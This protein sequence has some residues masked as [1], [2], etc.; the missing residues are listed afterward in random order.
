MKLLLINPIDRSACSFSNHFPPLGFG[1]LAALT[2]PDIQIEFID[3]NFEE[4]RPRK[5]DLVAISSMTIQANRTYEICRYYKSKGI[6]TIVGGIHVSMLPEEAL[7]YASSVIV[8]EAESLWPQAIQDFLD[9]QL[10]R[11]YKSSTFPSLGNLVT[12]RRDIFNKRYIYDTIQTSRGCPFTCDFCSVQVFNG[13]KYRLRPIEEVI[14]ELKSIKKKLVFFVDDNIIGHGDKNKERAKL[15]FEAIIRSGIKKYWISQASVNIAEDHELMKLM[16]ESGCMGL[17]IGFETTDTEKL[18]KY[19][20][21]Q[22]LKSG[23]NA[24]RYYQRS[25]KRLHEHGICVN[26]YFCYGYEDTPKS[27]LASLQYILNTP[28]DV[29]NTPIIVPSP[30][31]HLFNKLYP[32]IEYKNYPEDWKKFLGRLVLKPKASS[33]TDFYRSYIISSEKLISIL[34]IFKRSMTTLKHSKSLVQ[35][36][37]FFLINWN[38]RILRKKHMAFMKNEDRSFGKADRRI[39]HH[40][41]E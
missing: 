18:R 19:G 3:E 27:I 41:D 23:V 5:A 15:L 12:P 39:H 30:G 22:N 31:T 2:P 17:L 11:L 28:F 29:V 7:S 14:D 40:S 21:H 38:Y 33:K 20:K 36:I 25:V 4:F 6:P 9:G 13:K 26:G 8:G 32:E 34:E 24:G 37:V 35:T 10:N 16:K 1:Y